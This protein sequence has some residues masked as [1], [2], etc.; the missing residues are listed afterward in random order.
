[1]KKVITS[2]S[3][4]VLTGLASSGTL[5]DITPGYAEQG[6]ALTVFITGQNTDFCIDQ[7]SS[8]VNNVKD[9]YLELD[10]TIIE[11]GSFS[12]KGKTG[13][14]AGF[15]I[16]F[17]AA[18][19]VYDV[20]VVEISNSVTATLSNGFTIQDPNA[21]KII[22]VVPKA[23][24]QGEPLMV[25][26][27]GR[28]TNFCIYQGSE[29]INNVSN[30]YFKQ[31]NSVIEATGITIVNKTSLN[32]GFTI[33]IDALLGLYNVAVVQTSPRDTA[34]RI[35]GFTIDPPNTPK[36][37]TVDPDSAEQEQTLIVS[38]TGE[39]TDFRIDQGSGTTNN[40]STVYFKQFNTVIEANSFSTA[41]KTYLTAGF[42]IPANASVGVYDVAVVQNTKGDTAS[43]HD[44]F[45]ILL[46]IPEQMIA[47]WTF[48]ERQGDSAY[49]ISGNGNH[50]KLLNGV[51][52]VDGLNGGTAVAFDGI[53]DKGIC[54]DKP[55]H[56]DMKA[57][58]IETVI[59]INEYPSNNH[60]GPIITK[61][62]SGSNYDDSWGLDINRISP[63]GGH[64]VV[65]GTSTAS[66]VGT[67]PLPI[68]EWIHFVFT[69]EDKK[70]ALYLDGDKVDSNEVSSIGKIQ[71]SNTEM[72]LGHNSDPHYFNG[73]IDQVRL[74]NY[75]LNSE[76]VLA[77]YD[78]LQPVDIQDK[79]NTACPGK[80]VIKMNA[81]GFVIFNN[82]EQ[83]IEVTLY[84]TSGRKLVNNK[85][86]ATRNVIRVDMSNL[87]SGVYLLKLNSGSR[88]LTRRFVIRR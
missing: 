66:I 6:E 45:K 84:A 55:C 7:G 25:S 80:N 26:I 52:W 15:T 54:A 38:I 83:P 46:K 11:A 18:V 36:I 40:V 44:G 69:W 3:L 20:T 50:F 53:D 65:V 79:F 58:T 29:T 61:W 27:T 81:L 43:L 86:K 72:L 67:T 51:T 88:I 21:P 19:G 31:D 85:Y 42:T 23:G 68:R 10:N 76:T 48:D 8:T 47:H 5:I 74:Y 37:V 71:N 22:S 60:W 64:A 13:L 62:G 16:P 17:D 30:V 63:F 56:T 57:L 32:A 70:M 24:E 28:N 49:D 82:E 73:K 2:L 75:A 78:S 35:D 77:H 14:S 33:P 34:V 41:S 59:W 87:A 9:V 39:N 1:M 4:L 12:F